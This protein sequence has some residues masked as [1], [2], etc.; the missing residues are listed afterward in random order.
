MLFKKPRR[1]RVILIDPFKQGLFVLL[2]DPNDLSGLHAL[3]DC[4]LF[5]RVPLEPSFASLDSTLWVDESGWLREPFV[6]PQFG[7]YPHSRPLAGY[8]LLTGPLDG[9]SLML[10]ATNVALAEIAPLVLFEPWTQR[11]SPDAC[12]EQ[13]LRIYPSSQEGAL[14]L[15][16]P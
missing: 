13:L 14:L 3:L 11:L 6:Y 2:I 5:E 8:G 10:T 7:L 15:K 16:Q 12:I 1:I 9:E 4:A